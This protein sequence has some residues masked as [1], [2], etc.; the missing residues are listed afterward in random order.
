[1][2]HFL[3]VIKDYSK[4]GQDDQFV[5]YI[6]RWDL[7]K[8]EPTA[9]VSPPRKPIIFWI[10][11]TVP[12]RFRGAVREG[13]LE[14]NKTFEQAGFA[15]AIEVRQQ[16]DDATWDPED[17]NYN[18]FR[19]I[20]SDAGFAMGP[21]RVNPLTGQILDADIIFDASFI[22]HWTRALD[23]EK[24]GE[25]RRSLLRRRCPKLEGLLDR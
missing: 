16:P 22:E 17:I 13:I 23:L 15:N 19:W 11:N 25:Q 8:V 12:Y 1:M 20:T 24:P 2:G 21:S 9:K 5:R 18:T 6:N 3:T 14:W 10:E 4:T 7:R